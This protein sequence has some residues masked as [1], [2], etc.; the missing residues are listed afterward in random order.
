MKQG[1]FLNWSRAAQALTFGVALLGLST[2]RANTVTYYV[3]VD[4]I[5][6]AISASSTFQAFCGSS[7]A[8]DCGIFDLYL[9]PVVGS[10]ITYSYSNETVPSSP[11]GANWVDS[12]TNYS[13]NNNSTFG[14]S[15]GAAGPW[16]RFDDD[17]TQTGIALITANANTAGVSYSLPSYFGSEH[18]TGEGALDSNALFSVTVN[19]SGGMITGLEEFN[20]RADVIALNPSG[21]QV[22]G[23]ATELAFNLA[24]PEPRG[25]SFL[26]FA[27]VV[28]GAAFHRFRNR[29][30]AQ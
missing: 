18:Q 17:T 4:Q 19:Y 2:A 29:R 14:T 15:S 11:S 5:L 3:S 1:S 6:N 21:T 9:E 25:I 20:F 22:S 12:T 8:V 26:L 24:L 30:F 23:K 13:L 28:L 27:I 16:A 7:P 10:G